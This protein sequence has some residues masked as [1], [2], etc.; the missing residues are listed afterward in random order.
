MKIFAAHFHPNGFFLSAVAGA[1]FWF[2]LGDGAGWGRFTMIRPDKEFVSDGALFGICEV[3]PARS[4]PPL[5]VVEGSNVLWRLP[6]A[7]AVSQGPLVSL[8]QEDS[9]EGEYLRELQSCCH[10]T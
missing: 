10:E 6:E 9:K 1:D 7:I 8:L 5:S 2:Y 3:L 4:E